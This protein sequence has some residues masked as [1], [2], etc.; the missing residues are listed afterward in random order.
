MKRAGPGHLIVGLE[1]PVLART[2]AAWLAAHQPAGV[3]LFSRN[4]I[5]FSQLRNLCGVL[6]SLV[7]GLEIMVD[8]EGG[9]VSQA[10]AA[11]GRPPSAWGLGVLDD[12]GLTVRVHAETGRRLAAAGI[13]RVL[14][15][16]ADVLTEWRNPVIGSRAF[17][18]EAGAVGRQVV[19]AVTGLLQ[20]GVRVCVKHWPGHGGTDRDTHHASAAVEETVDGTPF[21]AALE[22]GADA[23][24]VGH[25]HMGGWTSSGIPLPATLDPDAL[26]KVKRSWGS[27]RRVDLIA[28]D[29]TM[30]GL[31]EAMA[32]LGVSVSARDSRGM[33]P[34]ELLPGLWLDHLVAAGCDLL[35]VRGI[36]YAAHPVPAEPAFPPTT[37]GE[38][39]KAP[40]F[41]EQPY[42]EA[43]ERLGR[44]ATAGFEDDGAD[45]FWLDF[46][47][48]DR[49]QAAAGATADPADLVAAFSGRFRSVRRVRAAE[50][51]PDDCRRLAV[52]SHRPL[53]PEALA[54]LETGTKGFCLALGHPSLARD[55]GAHLGRKWRIGSLFDVFAGDLPDIPGAPTKI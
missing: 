29:V 20:G 7:P 23:V 1:G 48:D 6:H 11:V 19:A 30:G 38:P 12:P 24:M 51:V 15:P 27:G 40:V 45:L 49:W 31:A 14:A 16:V 36:P 9:P 17:G 35:L 4:I 37:A 34:P 44:V 54:A 5:D 32:G 33:M 18:A 22:A 10:A 50:Q 39:A 43:R 55:L 42:A 21:A 53:A 3:V 47:S 46:S 26:A 2:E 41:A 8:H 25:L 52:S 28:D 13:D